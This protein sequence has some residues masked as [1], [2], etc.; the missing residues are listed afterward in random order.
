MSCARIAF[1]TWPLESPPVFAAA[2]LSDP[3]WEHLR[4][5]LWEQ[6]H[7]IALRAYGARMF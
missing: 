6:L 4:G 1:W 5:Q 7:A 3:L 2:S